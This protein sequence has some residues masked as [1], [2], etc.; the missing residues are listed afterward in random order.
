MYIF[1]WWNL[2]DFMVLLLMLADLILPQ[3]LAFVRVFRMTRVLRPLKLMC[4]TPPLPLPRHDVEIRLHVVSA[5]LGG[6]HSAFFN[7]FYCSLHVYTFVLCSQQHVTIHR[8][9]LQ[10]QVPVHPTDHSF[11]LRLSSPAFQH[12]HW[13]RCRHVRLRIAV[14]I[15]PPQKCN[16][17]SGFC[18]VL[19]ASVC[20]QARPSY[21]SV[22][23]LPAMP[24]ALVLR[25]ML[26]AFWFQKHG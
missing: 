15:S 17:F 10:V 3:D 20:L 12:F 5:A 25:C 11:P 22:L 26:T 21:A 23:P 2:F 7:L 16:S 24:L 19:W 1:D 9:H 8:R 14:L 6:S 4:N 18:G 13:A